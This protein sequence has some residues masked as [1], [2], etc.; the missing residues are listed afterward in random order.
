MGD[1][2]KLERLKNRVLSI[3]KFL[4][5]A[6]IINVVLTYVSEVFGYIVECSGADSNLYWLSDILYRFSD[7]LTIILFKI[8][9]Y[10]SMFVLPAIFVSGIVLTGVVAFK[11][12]KPKEFLD[13]RFLVIIIG[14]LLTLGLGW[15]WLP[16]MF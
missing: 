15:L 14:I 3:G 5:V 2:M 1:F 10:A 13:L 4:S 8:T 9:G 11:K 16:E 6:S 12:H 7:V